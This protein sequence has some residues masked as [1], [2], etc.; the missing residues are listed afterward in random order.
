M[1]PKQ[2]GIVHGRQLSV[3]AGARRLEEMLGLRLVRR[4]KEEVC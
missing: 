2:Q 3:N 4:I 1:A